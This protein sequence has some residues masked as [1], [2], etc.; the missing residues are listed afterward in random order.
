MSTRLVD[1]P[2]W[3]ERTPLDEVRSDAER[4]ERGISLDA[5]NRAPRPPATRAECEFSERPCRALR[6]W[7]HCGAR[8]NGKL[9]CVL[10]VEREH[11]I[12]ETAAVLGLSER[13]VERT[14]ARA[15]V[16]LRANARKG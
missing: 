12:A 13:L 8:G 3:V 11:T 10:D 5:W 14:H 7:Y 1:V 9:S 2:R 15:L 16:Q 6:C 4:R